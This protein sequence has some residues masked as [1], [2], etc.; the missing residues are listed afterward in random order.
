MA[1][2]TRDGLIASAKQQIRIIKT[3]SATTIA[4]IPF[5]TL[6]LAGYPGAGSLSVGNTANGLVPTDATSGFPVINAFGGGATGYLNAIDFGSSVACRL[7]LY[8]RLFHSGS[9]A[10]TPTGTV[11]L[12]SQPSYA[13]R[14]PNTDYENLELFLEINTVVAASAVTIAV[15]YTKEDGTT[16]RATPA[17]SSLSAFTTR[18]LIPMALQAGDKGIQKIE[19]FT[20]GGTAAATGNFN[21][22]VARRLWSN[23]V[24]IANDGGVDG[25][26]RTGL[27]VVFDTSALWMVVE[28]DSTSSGIPEL[29]FTIANG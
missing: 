27:P 20:I 1:I 14:L 23:R 21:I 19:G 4:A 3:A 17:S 7:T 24:K 28:A 29:A 10:M 15:N 12:A 9:H 13:G 18:R 22:V 26:D 11:N 8:D 6:D 2:T 5:T 16:G 25:P